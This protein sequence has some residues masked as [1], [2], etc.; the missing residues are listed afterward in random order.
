M[1]EIYPFPIPSQP[2]LTRLRCPLD[3]YH[4]VVAHVAGV[5]KGKLD[6][7]DLRHTAL[8]VIEDMS[9]GASPDDDPVRATVAAVRCQETLLR[10]VRIVGHVSTYSAP[11]R[12]RVVEE[13]GLSTTVDVARAQITDLDG[14]SIDAVVVGDDL[15][16][17]LQ[18]HARASGRCEFV[19]VPIA[20]PSRVN[21][22]SPT[23][24]AGWSPSDYVLHLVE[25]GRPAT[26]L[27]LIGA[28]DE[29]RAEAERILAQLHD[30]GR[31]PFEF[32]VES[33]VREV[34]LIGYGDA[35]ELT[36]GVDACVLQGMSFGRLDDSTSACIH[37]MIPGPPGCGKGELSRTARTVQ[38]AYVDVA[39]GSFSTAGLIGASSR[40][41]GEW[42]CEPGAIPC[43]RGGVV[44]AQDAHAWS[45]SA[46]QKVA[47]VMQEAMQEGVVRKT[48]AGAA[49]FD[50]CSSFL[51]DLNLPRQ[52]ARGGEIQISAG[53]IASV[54]PLLSRFDV[55]LEFPEDAQRAWQLSRQMLLGSERQA[56]VHA[57]TTARLLKVLV[58]ML[59]DR[60]PWI[61]LS[62][63]TE[64]M[65][66]RFDELYEANRQ[67]IETHPEAGD[68]PARLTVK[69]KRLVTAHARGQD[70]SVARPED[71]DA[72]MPFVERTVAYLL[73]ADGDRGIPQDSKSAAFAWMAVQR[74]E[75]SVEEW[76][77]QY[78]AN[79]RVVI[80]SKTME[81]RLKEAGAK[82]GHGRFRLPPPSV[83]PVETEAQPETDKWTSGHQRS[84]RLFR[85]RLPRQRRSRWSTSA[86]RG[87]G[88]GRRCILAR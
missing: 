82:V 31:S 13:S 21:V 45:S 61:D 69:M 2:Q 78:N 7:D 35:V 77:A 36:L 48:T 88:R 57:A 65:V 73:G 40:R 74:G 86:S 27:D 51:V 25:I 50:A 4:A 60:H 46:V 62:Q 72:I 24:K 32:L 39:P 1:A 15:V 12:T 66:R 34:G 33:V 5:A 58:A 10:P 67:L 23:D 52:L 54:R 6:L 87:R 29:E 85:R 17:K 19:A 83:E 44:I 81:R 64:Q 16:R 80:S 11:R 79:A 38:P 42:T 59:R 56:R 14:E 75:H 55:I 26:Q 18:H 3:L 37:I 76:T 68:I 9:G 70:R 41:N 71:V 30:E 20:L 43:A 53:A 22:K 28:T 47:P 8:A 63:V 84:R 49:E